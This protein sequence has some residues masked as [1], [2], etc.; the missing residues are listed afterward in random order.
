MR[1]LLMQHRDRKPSAPRNEFTHGARQKRRLVMESRHGLKRS[2][3]QK[4]Q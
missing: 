3:K 2:E 4:S 1:L